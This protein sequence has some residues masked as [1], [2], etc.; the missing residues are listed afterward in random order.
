MVARTAGWLEKGEH[1]P[2]SVFLGLG[3][4]SR[5]AVVQRPACP[6][7]WMHGARQGSKS[8]SDGAVHTKLPNTSGR[9]GRV[10]TCS[11]F[12]LPG[13]LIAARAH[14]TGVSPALTSPG[15]VVARSQQQREDCNH[16]LRP[17]GSEQLPGTD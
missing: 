10:S 13:A 14:V 11:S 8:R 16:V 7:G 1:S 4:A 12:V 15:V 5:A 6:S 3:L 9:S 17:S 2:S